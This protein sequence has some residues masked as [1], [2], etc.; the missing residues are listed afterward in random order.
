VETAAGYAAIAHGQAVA[1]GMVAA[2][3]IAARR[4]LISPEQEA[5]IT[6]VLS[7]LH[8]PVR[9]ADMGELPNEVKDSRALK[10]IMLRD[11]KAVAGVVRFVLPVGLGDAAVFSDVTAEEIDAGLAAL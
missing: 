9:W 1:L 2:A 7:A 6:A 8:L 11:K 4:G 3:R 5:R 10:A